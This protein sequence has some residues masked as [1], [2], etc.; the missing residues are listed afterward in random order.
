MCNAIHKFNAKVFPL[1]EEGI[2]YKV[3]A[4]KGNRLLPAFNIYDTSSTEYYTHEGE[5]VFDD[6]LL[7]SRNLNLK[8]ETD[9]FCFM[10]LENEAS[11]LAGLLNKSLDAA[12]CGLNYEFSINIQADSFVVRKVK[13][14]RGKIIRMDNFHTIEFGGYKLI[15][16]HRF[17]PLFEDGETL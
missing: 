14:R 1:K 4:K 5:I 13:Y 17:T 6:T 11:K 16:A 12:N 10:S 15:I 9:G 8:N 3:F 7:S 2:A